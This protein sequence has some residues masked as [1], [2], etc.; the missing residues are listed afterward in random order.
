MM[1]NG[2]QNLTGCPCFNLHLPLQ[3]GK[4][5]DLHDPI[6]VSEE[7]GAVRQHT[8]W[9]EVMTD[10]DNAKRTAEL[11]R[12]SVLLFFCILESC[13]SRTRECYTIR[14][15]PQCVIR[16]ERRQVH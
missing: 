13:D 10:G 9:P 14:A 6:A 7:L 8:A 12:L 3:L 15:F 5:L 1:Q 11:N 4:R 2:Q 16:Q